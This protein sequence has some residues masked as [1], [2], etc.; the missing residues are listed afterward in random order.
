MQNYDS[1]RSAA[2][3]IDAHWD[4]SAPTFI[5]LPRNSLFHASSE[6][7]A[8]L[9]GNVDSDYRPE[10]FIPYAGTYGVFEY[11]TTNSLHVDYMDIDDTG[12]ETYPRSPGLLFDVDGDGDHELFY[13]GSIANESRIIAIDWINDTPTKMWHKTIGTSSLSCF[14]TEAGNAQTGNFTYFPVTYTDDSGEPYVVFFTSN[15]SLTRQIDVHKIHAT[16]GNTTTLSLGTHSGCTNGVGAPN[17]FS[18]SFTST[19]WRSFDTANVAGTIPSVAPAV[20]DVGLRDR[21]YVPVACWGTTPSYSLGLMAIFMDTFQKDTSFDGT[22]YR[23][24]DTFTAASDQYTSPMCVDSQVLFVGADSGANEMAIY[25]A[26]ETTINQVDEV[27]FGSPNLEWV[28]DLFVAE[29]S[30]AS[31][32]EYD[33]ICFMARDAA[34]DISSL[35]CTDVDMPLLT[36]EIYMESNFAQTGYASPLIHVSSPTHSLYG[37]SRQEIITNMG[38]FQPEPN[39]FSDG[40]NDWDGETFSGEEL[41]FLPLYGF[42]DGTCVGADIDSSGYGDILCIGS[43]NITIILSSET[44]LPV[45]LKQVGV[46]VSTTMCPGTQTYYI[47]YQ[48]G[49]G[50]D[51]PES[52]DVR[53]SIDC[54]SN[55]TV[56]YSTYQTHGSSFTFSCPYTSGTHSAIIGI[57]DAVNGNLDTVLHTTV[58][59]NITGCDTPDNLVSTQIDDSG[60]VGGGVDTIAPTDLSDD[61]NALFPVIGIRKETTREAVLILLLIIIGLAYAASMQHSSYPIVP[62]IA[63]VIYMGL[64]AFTLLGIMRPYVLIITTILAIAAASIYSGMF[65]GRGNG[66]GA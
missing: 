40:A 33:D 1:A 35:Y 65:G 24:I 13:C 62:I 64:L 10:I 34:D 22:G 21:L 66:G 28:S 44:N 23:L 48:N 26:T 17:T 31:T 8:P 50:Y 18:S 51:D 6:M 5:A 15:A 3:P 9:I 47:T 39:G 52:D 49:A 14:N 11:D 7:W 16:S 63:I 37:D 2:S 25:T 46:D 12:L 57:E 55:T 43:K 4:T 36:D 30:S 42:I 32:I 29:L 53:A 60:D 59:S 61:L 38:I 45:D 27:A 58:V 54:E 41:R 20:C 56:T 19:P